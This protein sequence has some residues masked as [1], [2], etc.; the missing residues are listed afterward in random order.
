MTSSKKSPNSLKFVVTICPKKIGENIKKGLAENYFERIYA[1]NFDPKLQKKDPD[2]SEV[3]NEEKK[4]ILTK[5]PSLKGFTRTG[6]IKNME[7]ID[8]PVF[9]C[10]ENLK[11]VN[12]YFSGNR[13]YT[14]FRT[15]K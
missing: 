2:I 12:Y 3:K 6:A 14:I 13:N 10:Y 15:F 9:L 4:I 11:K 5:K 7:N 8:I 1:E